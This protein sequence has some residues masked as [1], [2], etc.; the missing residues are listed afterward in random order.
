LGNDRDGSDPIE[1][2]AQGGQIPSL[3]DVADAGPGDGPVASPPVSPL[4]KGEVVDKAADSSKLAE[5]FFLFGS[6][7]EAES[8]TSIDHLFLAFAMHVND[9]PNEIG[10]GNP[11]AFSFSL[12]KFHLGISE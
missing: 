10:N 3:R 9:A 5:Q 1:L 12:E 2:S 6:R 11:K 4:F 7:I 8:V